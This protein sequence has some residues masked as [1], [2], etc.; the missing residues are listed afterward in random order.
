MTVLAFFMTPDRIMAAADSVSVRPDGRQ[1][2][3]HPKLQVNALARSVCAGTG[4]S[5]VLLPAYA[6][7]AEAAAFDDIPS[8]VTRALRRAALDQQ[9]CFDD[10]PR[11]FARHTFVCAGWSQASGRM[12]AYAFTGWSFFVPVLATNVVLPV[13]RELPE[14]WQPSSTGDLLKLCRRQADILVAEKPRAGEGALMTCELTEY[15][16]AVAT[17]RDYHKGDESVH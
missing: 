2:T 16:L 3:H 14:M 11:A 6:V 12:L 8:K 1:V 17:V 15:C 4:F 5:N 13:M 9:R 7:C 10:D